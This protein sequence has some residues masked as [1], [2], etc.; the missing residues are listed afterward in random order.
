MLDPFGVGLLPHRG[1]ARAVPDWDPAAG[2]G[3][4]RGYRAQ[5]RLRPVRAG[6][7]QRD[8]AA[9][10]GHGVDTVW[11][12]AL[13]KPANPFDFRTVTER[14]GLRKKAT[15]DHQRNSTTTLF[16]ALE[17]PPP[18]RRPLLRPARQSRVPG[19][20]QDRGARLSALT[21][22][23]G[24]RQLPHPQA[25]RDHCV[26]GKTVASHCISPRHQDPG[27]TW[28]KYPSDHHPPDHPPRLLRQ[29]Q[30]LLPESARSSPAE[31]HSFI[32]TTTQV[33]GAVGVSGATT[34]FIT[35]TETR[36]PT[37]TCLAS[38]ACV[39]H[40]VT[41]WPFSGHSRWDLVTKYG[42]SQVV[43]AFFLL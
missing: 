29:R 38:Q 11:R 17:G 28:S 18:C 3:G 31:S 5:Q 24:A 33:V 15:H 14:A 12:L 10:R 39:P 13:P 6:T 2:A 7:R 16:A 8:A 35:G 25:R 34:G 9:V 21:T 20:P 32:R 26:V 36:A 27:S 40:C 30:G 4:H 22:A 37:A 19:L 1:G 42:K 43:D 41:N 23:G